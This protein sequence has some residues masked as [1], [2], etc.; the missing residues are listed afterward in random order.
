MQSFNGQ[1]VILLDNKALI[2]TESTISFAHIT[3]CDFVPKSGARL[4]DSMLLTSEQGQ[5]YRMSS[6]GKIKD[7]GMLSVGRWDMKNR[8]YAV[9]DKKVFFF[10]DHRYALIGETQKTNISI[11]KAKISN[12][13]SEM[14]FVD[15]NNSFRLKTQKTDKIISK[16]ILLNLPYGLTSLMNYR[17]DWNSEGDVLHQGNGVT[18]EMTM[19]SGRQIPID[20]PE[21]MSAIFD[22]QY[23]KEM[24]VFIILYHN[25][26]ISMVD[27]RGE[28]KDSETFKSSSRNYLLCDCGK[29]F[30]IV[31]R[32]RLVQQATLF[33][34]TAL[35]IHDQNGQM[36]FE[37]HYNGIASDPVQN[38]TYDSAE[39]ILY[40][41]T[42][43]NVIRYDLSRGFIAD[44]HLLE[45]FI[46]DSCGLA[47]NNG[48]LYYH[49]QEQGLCV[50][51]LKSGKRIANLP[52]HR[53][54]SN[55]S[56]CTS[57]IAVMENNEIIYQTK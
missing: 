27:S 53:S 40:V 48:L 47:V 11:I 24:G 2:I 6:D 5:I 56:P 13:S 20:P 34:E 51:D 26:K 43:K 16:D 8:I 37:T 10:S 18:A 15:E 38:I 39:N 45:T 12:N 9:G 50:L 22:I 28:K 32:R 33:E 54:I 4:G 57:G 36:V 49:Q 29:Y 23:L 42:T 31:A 17:C 55:I 14:L 44:K 21:M 1:L 7:Y 41:I 25:G 30:C 35:A 19:V 46:P 3:N 52:T